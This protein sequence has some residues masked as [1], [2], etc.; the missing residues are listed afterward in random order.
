[1]TYLVLAVVAVILLLGIA[2]AIAVKTA[3]VRG[4]TIGD[5]KTALDVAQEQIIKQQAYQAKIQEAQQNADAKKESLH[6]GDAAADFNSSL[7]V[8]HGASK[9]RGG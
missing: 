1:M 5:L 4:R 2:L 7:G 9:N 3:S 6:T 8:L